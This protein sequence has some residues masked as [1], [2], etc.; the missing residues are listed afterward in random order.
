MEF[1][2]F[3]VGNGVAPTTEATVYTVA[4]DTSV[5]LTSILLSNRSAST[6]DVSIWVNFGSGKRLLTPGPLALPGR[7]L[8]EHNHS[9]ALPVGSVVSI[10]SSVASYVDYV[11]SG[12]IASTAV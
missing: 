2:P 3:N 5:L 4:A 7:N 12:V 10:Q 9:V 8:Y 1:V 11:I 6:I